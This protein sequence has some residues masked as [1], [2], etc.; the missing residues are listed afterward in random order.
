MK[1]LRVHKRSRNE[2][3]RAN[4]TVYTKISIFVHDTCH[5]IIPTGYDCVSEAMFM[6]FAVL[7]TKIFVRYRHSA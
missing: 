6:A 5:D 7:K 2:F 1:A 3:L 4:A